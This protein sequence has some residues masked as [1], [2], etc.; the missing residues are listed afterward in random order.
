MLDHLIILQN[1]HD[2]LNNENNYDTESSLK[3]NIKEIQYRSHEKL[4]KAVYK[5]NQ[6]ISSR[7]LLFKLFLVLKCHGK[8]R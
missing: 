6:K 3:P 1:T 5:V 7:S 4:L 8:M 2:A